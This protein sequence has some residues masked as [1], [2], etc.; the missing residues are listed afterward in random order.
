MY[1]KAEKP[2]EPLRLAVAPVNIIV[3]C[4]GQYISMIQ[5]QGIRKNFNITNL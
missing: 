2:A 5:A 3:P 4:P 1:L